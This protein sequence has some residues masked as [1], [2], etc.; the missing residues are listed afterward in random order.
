M[1]EQNE[2]I[3]RRLEELDEI[4]V[5]SNWLALNKDKNKVLEIADFHKKEDI[6]K[7]IYS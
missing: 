3:K 7:F 1:N 5:I 2:L 4:K 6:V